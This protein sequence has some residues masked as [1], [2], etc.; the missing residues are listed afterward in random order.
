MGD[1]PQQPKAGY[2][3]GSKQGEI[4]RWRHGLAGSNFPPHL[5][6]LKKRCDAFRRVVEKDVLRLRGKI[7]LTEAL[8]ID[9][10]YKWERHSQLSSRFL[11]ESYDKITPAERVT[12][13]REAAR[14]A[15]L[16]NAAIKSLRLDEVATDTI[17]DFF[18]GNIP[19]ATDGTNE[20]S[21]D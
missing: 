9:A 13:S 21:T 1:E 19:S 4:R 16:R 10:A 7:T 8:A 6:D 11:R 2:R 14:A 5:T 17:D 3:G 18:N 12:Y 20:Q 15:D